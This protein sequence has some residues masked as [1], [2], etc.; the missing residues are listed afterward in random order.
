MR[1]LR[2]TAHTQD[3]TSR[4]YSLIKA[5]LKSS[6]KP[7]GTT[8]VAKMIGQVLGVSPIKT[9][10]LIKGYTG[11]LGAY[12]LE[13]SDLAL[14]SKTLQG[15]NRAVLPTMKITEYPFF[16]EVLYQR[17]WWRRERAVL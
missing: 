11:T 8:E 13:I 1:F 4:R 14:R 17:V 15:D 6:K 7:I 2:T 10:Y 3:E 16:K 5:R 12:I 9:E